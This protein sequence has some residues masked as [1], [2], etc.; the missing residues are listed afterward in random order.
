MK[1]SQKN[2]THERLS[3]I[4]AMTVLTLAERHVR[5]SQQSEVCLGAFVVAHFAHQI[6][7]ESAMINPDTETFIGNDMQLDVLKEFRILRSQ[8][9]LLDCHITVSTICF[10]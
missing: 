7:V 1:D 9:I 6:L 4:G 10:H 2:C 5:S 8:N 3:F